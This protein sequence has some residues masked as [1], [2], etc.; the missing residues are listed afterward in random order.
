MS[1]SRVRQSFTHSAYAD[2]HARWYGLY[3]FTWFQGVHRR[4][5]GDYKGIPSSG[6]C[7]R[8]CSMDVGATREFV[9]L[10]QDVERSYCNAKKVI[11]QLMKIPSNYLC[12]SPKD[13][14]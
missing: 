6:L 8:L 4:D 11:V 3:I 5:Y 14:A 13:S 10:A 2:F 1:G 12:R 9:N 7:G